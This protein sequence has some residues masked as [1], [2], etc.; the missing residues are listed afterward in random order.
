MVY[1]ILYVIMFCILIILLYIVACA[2]KALHSMGIVH[3]DLKPVS[4]NCHFVTLSIY[5]VM[6]SM[7]SSSLDDRSIFLFN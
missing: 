6:S 2:L 4:N 1:S 7:S 3:R 5:Y